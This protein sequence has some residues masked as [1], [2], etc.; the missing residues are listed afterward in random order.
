MRL[1][2]EEIKRIREEHNLTQQALADRIY[3]TRQAISKWECD[4]AFPSSDVIK[5]IKEEFNVDL[6]ELI[7]E[8]DIKT[9]IIKNNSELNKLKKSTKLL[10]I[11]SS[12][13]LILVVFI[14]FLFPTKYTSIKLNYQDDRI[15][16]TWDDEWR[17][18]GIY[19]DGEFIKNIN[20]A[21]YIIE[22]DKIN[23]ENGSIHTFKVETRNI[24]F[25]KN[26]FFK[27]E[28]VKINNNKE[29]VNINDVKDN[30]YISDQNG[31][32]RINF[33]TK[34]RGVYK[35]LITLNDEKTNTDQINMDLYCY[36]S[37]TVNEEMALYC[38]EE[39]YYLYLTGSHPK[40]YCDEDGDIHVPINKYEL[41]I[42]TNEPFAILNVELVHKE[43]NMK[44]CLITES[45][46][47]KTFNR[48]YGIDHSVINPSMHQYEVLNVV[49][50]LNTFFDLTNKKISINSDDS[51]SSFG[52]ILFDL[53]ENVITYG[54]SDYQ[55][56]IQNFSFSFKENQVIED[57][58]YIYIYFYLG[59]E[60]NYP[61][62][63]D[64]TFEISN[65]ND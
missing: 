28:F 13:L 64:F 3:V 55:N 33:Q 25:I 24:I 44:D 49:Y 50:K 20:G 10:I 62:D 30:N 22:M 8:E 46:C 34:L 5:K 32:L 26:E 57:Y 35:L 65:T 38:Y 48:D 45:D 52:V 54:H 18:Y 9:S 60:E 51:L 31:K 27:T 7:T 37:K 19:I 4:K 16:A 58:I 63:I 47:F 53:N 15:I 29:Y 43:I 40:K 36:C 41:Y 12:I 1:L 56:N 11:I 2:S 6:N 21:H 14:I 23:G 42:R 17:S 59:I 39:E 61:Y